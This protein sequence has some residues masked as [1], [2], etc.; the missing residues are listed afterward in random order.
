MM[1]LACA[2]LV[3]LALSS[4]ALA[5][6]DAPPAPQ[7]L[8]V[9]PVGKITFQGTGTDQTFPSTIEIKA[10]GE[11]YRLDALG[12]GMRRKLIIKVYEGVAYADAGVDLGDNPYKSLIEGDF[13]KRIEMYFV[14]DVDGGKIRGAFEDG[15]KKTIP[16][17]D[18]TPALKAN[19]DK[20]LAEFTDE[21]VKVGQTISITW[22][23]G[24]GLYTRIA[25]RP[26][27]PINDRDLAQALWAIWFGADPVNQGLKRAM[28][29]FVREVQGD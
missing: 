27:P 13:P 8:N 23:P 25:G 26:V 16:E 9:S 24:M 7:L 2:A 3:A 5:Q 6:E 19:I 22:M 15:F 14:H 4:A 20:F 29:R 28:V 1:K 17:E 11:G 12:S 18:M 21:G 10:R